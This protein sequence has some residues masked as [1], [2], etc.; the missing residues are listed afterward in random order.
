MWNTIVE[1]LPTVGRSEAYSI[2]FL[3]VLKMKVALVLFYLSK[4]PN[5]RMFAGEI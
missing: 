1:K 5:M 3:V 2:L 4:P